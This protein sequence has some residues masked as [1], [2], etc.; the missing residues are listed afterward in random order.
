MPTPLAVELK[1]QRQAVGTALELRAARALGLHNS[2]SEAS[3]ASAPCQGGERVELSGGGG[4]VHARAPAMAG[5]AS[6]A[7]ASGGIGEW[8]RPRSPGMRRAT[9]RPR[10]GAASGRGRS[11][12]APSAGHRRCPL[13]TGEPRWVPATTGPSARACAKRVGRLGRL[14]TAKRRL[15]STSIPDR[16][17]RGGRRREAWRCP[18]ARARA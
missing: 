6:G 17:R 5:L 2:T 13:V 12:A 9:R 1:G 16:D 18:A 7:L 10:T 15:Q 8:S 14:P 3:I 11:S 4:R